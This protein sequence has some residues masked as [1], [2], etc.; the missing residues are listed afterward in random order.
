[1]NFDLHDDPNP[2]EPSDALR[3]SIVSRA[4]HR[5]AVRR[6]ATLA[7]LVVAV[8]TVAVL[9][10]REPATT[11]LATTPA[12]STTPPGSYEADA[13][14]PATT[15]PVVPPGS[16]PS[17]TSRRPTVPSS[18]TPTTP[19]RPDPTTGHEPT[20][21]HVPPTTLPMATT[22]STSTL[23][24]PTT[25]E[26]SDGQGALEG[27]TDGRNAVSFWPVLIYP[28]GAT[29]GPPSYTVQPAA[30][31]TFRV[32]VV[33]G[34]YVVVHGSGVDVVCQS[35]PVTVTSRATVTVTFTCQPY[36]GGPL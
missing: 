22:T 29:S 34:T 12:K 27:T 1:M 17:T 15:A 19:A 35:A 3:A 14:P 2:T 6:G 9:H 10:A 26:L 4:R 13:G 33:T 20:T 28:V 30:D 11:T 32:V 36:H 18:V 21:L 25:T 8:S 31:G 16:D 24:V 5:R 7:T 23:P